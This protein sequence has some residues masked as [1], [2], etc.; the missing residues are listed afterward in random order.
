MSLTITQTSPD[1]TLP[2]EALRLSINGG[3]RGTF[4]NA[5]A[6]VVTDL[7]HDGPLDNVHVV[8][9]DGDAFT[10][11]TGTLESFDTATGTLTFADGAR[12]ALDDVLAFAVEG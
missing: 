6:H 3:W 1:E 10:R 11:S 2:S 9:H 12:R 5:V 8:T 4:A 7:L